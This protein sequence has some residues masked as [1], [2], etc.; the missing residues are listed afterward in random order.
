MDFG[1]A[2]RGQGSGWRG[3]PEVKYS[4]ARYCEFID[5]NVECSAEDFEV[6]RYQSSISKAAANI[7]WRKGNLLETSLVDIFCR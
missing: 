7:L 4:I 6:Q 5:G 1:R 3:R 2:H